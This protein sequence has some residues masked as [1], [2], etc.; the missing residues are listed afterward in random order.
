MKRIEE[1]AATVLEHARMYLARTDIPATGDVCEAI[2]L[3]FH[4]E[5]AIRMENS[6]Y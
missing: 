4:C 6:Q 1:A 2:I 3:L 5:C